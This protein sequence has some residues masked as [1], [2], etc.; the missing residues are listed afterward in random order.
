MNNSGNK[1]NINEIKTV[2]DNKNIEKTEKND[3]KDFKTKRLIIVLIAI[4]VILLI[5]L[6]LVIS[7]KL[8]PNTNT[9]YEP[10][11]SIQ[12]DN[13]TKNNEDKKDNNNVE[14]NKEESKKTTDNLSEEE[15][16]SNQKSKEDESSLYTKF[17]DWKD[18][19]FEQQKNHALVVKSNQQVD[20][21]EEEIGIPIGACGGT[22]L[23]LLEKDISLDDLSVS[24]KLDFLISLIPKKKAVLGDYDL[25]VLVEFPEEYAK[26]FFDDIS[27]LSTINNN[28]EYEGIYPYHLLKKNNNYYILKYSYGCTIGNTI[29]LNIDFKKVKKRENIS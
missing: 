27:F 8:K 25:D 3:D 20:F 6:M 9:N 13:I 24:N 22:S 28:I 29:G 7:I 5:I 4:I 2:G 23:P 10:K 15:A 16:D 21:S 17:E 1:K 14:S 12:E 26:N 19:E 11:N 18:K